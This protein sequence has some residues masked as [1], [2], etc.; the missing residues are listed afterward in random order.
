MNKKYS[1]LARPE[2]LLPI[3][4]SEEVKF[5]FTSV[6]LA[7]GIVFEV[8]EHAPMT[9]VAETRAIAVIIFFILILL[10]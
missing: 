8:E 6:L 1:T 10:L 9:I 4:I 3:S 5:R 2:I 7:P